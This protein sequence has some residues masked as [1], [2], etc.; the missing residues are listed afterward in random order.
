M[1]IGEFEEVGEIIKSF[2]SDQAT[3]VVGTVIDP[4]M[5]DE[6]R[7]T[8]VVT[9]LEESMSPQDPRNWQSSQN[10]HG[11]HAPGV[12]NHQAGNMQFRARDVNQS[13]NFAQP[14]HSSQPQH[15]SRSRFFGG[16]KKEQEPALQTEMADSECSQGGQGGQGGGSDRNYLDIPAFLRRKQSS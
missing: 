6:L 5:S 9:G 11:R 8:I 4:D 16:G 14:N 15:S 10:M 3:V 13:K 12:S 7:V 1:S 2:A